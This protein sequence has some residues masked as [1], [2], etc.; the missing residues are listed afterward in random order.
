M[1]ALSHSSSSSLE[2]IAQVN[3]LSLEHGREK[4]EAQFPAG[5]CNKAMDKKIIKWKQAEE[6]RLS[7]EGSALDGGMRLKK[8]AFEPRGQAQLKNNTEQSSQSPGLTRTL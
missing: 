2:N 3:Y 1:I 6:G 8:R 5:P 7:E 4:I